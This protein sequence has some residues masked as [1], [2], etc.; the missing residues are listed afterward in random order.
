MPQHDLHA[1][2]MA[3][4]QLDGI[5]PAGD[6]R[7]ESRFAPSGPLSRARVCLKGEQH[8]RDADVVDLSANGMRLA[9]AAGALCREGESCTIAISLSEQRELRLSGDIRWVQPHRAITVFG[10]LLDPEHTPLQPV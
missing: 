7:S 9:V 8:W 10:V 1:F 5:E 4:R 6:R 3:L 2:R